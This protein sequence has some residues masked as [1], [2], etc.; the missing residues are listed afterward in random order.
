[1]QKIN[2]TRNGNN[3]EIAPDFE[4]K[5]I[6]TQINN[7]KYRGLKL[8]NKNQFVSTYQKIGVQLNENQ[9]EEIKNWIKEFDSLRV[10]ENEEKLK[11]IKNKEVKVLQ[12]KFHNY[13]I[14]R[15]IH[16]ENV[17]INGEYIY[18]DEGNKIIEALH[19]LTLEQLDK[20]GIKRTDDI[21]QKVTLT[22]EDKKFILAQG[23]NNRVE[24]ERE[25]ERINKEKM[26]KEEQRK[27]ET[28]IK[29]T[30]MLKK[31]IKTGEKQVLNSSSAL[32]DDGNLIIITEYIHPD[33]HVEKSEFY[34][35]D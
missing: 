16:T 18:S 28:E 14:E 7:K 30:E 10:Q 1:M 29:K 31:A 12:F 27:K 32:A 20:I 34:D 22:D 15:Y 23:E 35:G 11:E 5:S 2:I 8:N 9:A 6:I 19:N 4:K 26:E 13:L 25:I 3:V 33:G 24:T 17:Q 21:W